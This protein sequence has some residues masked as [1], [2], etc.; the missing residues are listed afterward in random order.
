M[1]SPANPGRFSL[2]ELIKFGLRISS[3]SAPMKIESWI[4]TEAAVYDAILAGNYEYCDPSHNG[5]LV[6]T[7]EKL[8]GVAELKVL[9]DKKNLGLW[10]R[11]TKR[12]WPGISDTQ[13]L[14]SIRQELSYLFSTCVEQATKVDTA[15]TH[16]PHNRE[17]SPEKD[18]T[19]N[20]SVVTS[21]ATFVTEANLEQA[22]INRGEKGEFSSGAGP[23][24]LIFLGVDDRRRSVYF[25][26]AIP[27]GPVG[28]LELNGNWFIWDRKDAI[29]QVYYLQ[30]S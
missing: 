7:E 30:G 21:E 12:H 14:D 18:P 2:L 11:L 28:Q 20:K 24:D 15:P 1:E 5:V 27:R 16:E 4:Q 6:T 10:V 19:G 3:P 29:A 25:Q 26:S 17:F 8:S 9:G 13:Q 23:L 22:D